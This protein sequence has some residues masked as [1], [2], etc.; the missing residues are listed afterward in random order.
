M[1]S[2]TTPTES[3]EAV[4]HN[5]ECT[6][7]A[8]PVL[9]TKGLPGGRRC[10]G[11]SPPGPPGPAWARVL[12]RPGDRQPPGRGQ[13]GRHPGT[14]L[15]QAL[16]LPPR[17]GPRVAGPAAGGVQGRLCPACQ[18][19]AQGVQAHASLVTVARQRA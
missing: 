8:P 17:L 12:A 1:T 16:Q 6:V 7:T 18:Q 3:T 14:E 13:A 15:G 4:P 5:K 11:S 19:P 2:S 10:G 9:P